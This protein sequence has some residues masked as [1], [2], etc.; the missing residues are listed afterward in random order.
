ML[1]LTAAIGLLLCIWC[2]RGKRIDDHPVCRKCGYDLSGAPEPY[3]KCSECGADLTTKRAM[4]KG[5]RKKLMGSAMVTGVVA[6]VAAVLLGMMI[7]NTFGGTSINAYKPFWLLKLEATSTVLGPNDQALDELL[8]RAE[9]GSLSSGQLDDLMDATLKMQA[10]MSIPWDPTWGDVF[11]E[12]F[13]RGVGTPK[14]REQYAAG[15]YAF[16]IKVRPRV[17]LGDSIPVKKYDAY[18]RGHGDKAEY[19]SYKLQKPI[20]EIDGSVTGRPYRTTSTLG[21]SDNPN[22]ED[23]GGTQ[24]RFNDEELKSLAAGTHTLKLIETTEIRLDGMT[25]ATIDRT[26]TK[27]F[28]IVSADTDDIERIHDPAAAALME[29]GVTVDRNLIGYHYRL[30]RDRF[31]VNLKIDGTTAPFAYAINAKSGEDQWWLGTIACNSP[32]HS[33]SFGFVRG[34]PD[35][36]VA[37]RVDLI[38]RPDPDAARET[39]DVFRILDHEFV[40]KDVRVDVVRQP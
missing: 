32:T 26:S 4:R 19:R 34:W 3:N 1:G 12:L 30:R 18:N 10:D 11:A 31:L 39:I 27:N 22:W 29:K 17:R 8:L 15:I 14:Q 5:N 35:N 9:S 16:D 7:F 23:V 2:L 20:I 40:I 36:F 13:T 37:E 33:E 28:E 25:V 24:V 21:F 38:F 6:L